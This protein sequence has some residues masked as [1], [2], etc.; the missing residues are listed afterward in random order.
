MPYARIIGGVVAK[1]TASSP[2]LGR[3]ECALIVECGEAVQVGWLFH[4]GV[5]V[6]PPEPPAPDPNAGIDAQ[7]LALE[8]TVT[9]RRLREA[10]LTDEGRAWLAD[11]D[12][13]IAALRAQRV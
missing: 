2:N 9:N 8:A 12:A 3:G 1:I 7:I 11:L 6:E 13:Q 10:A 4:G 5:I